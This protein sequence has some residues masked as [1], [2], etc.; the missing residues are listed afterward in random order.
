[1]SGTAKTVLI[2]AGAGVGVFVLLKV[3]Q[4][5]PLVRAYNQQPSAAGTVQ[6]LV[7]IGSALKG[8]FGSSSGS[9]SS[10]LGSSTISNVPGQYIFNSADTRQVG[11]ELV[12]TATGQALVYGTD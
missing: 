3:L 1:M 4:P 7:G 10:S 12:D 9:S 2:V 8:L 5:S 11:N 6:G